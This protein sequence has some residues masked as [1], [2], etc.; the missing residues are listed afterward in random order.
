MKC[1]GNLS[2][3]CLDA[4]NAF[5]EIERDCI[6]AALLA[7]PSLHLMLP[8]FDMLYERGS[9][10]LWFCDEHGNYVESHFSRSGV[11]KGCVLG[12]FLL[13]LAMNHVYDRVGALMGPDGVIYAYSDEVN[14]LSDPARMRTTLA[15]TPAIYMKVGLR[16]GW[17]L[18]KTG[19]ILPANSD[20]TT[21]LPHLDTGGGC[22]PHVVPGFL[23]CLKVLRHASNDPTFIT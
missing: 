1:D 2:A 12:A 13:C 20:P 19:L 21:F 18:G 8:M 7:N 22:L 23:S 17:G 11:R 14:L 4:I 16:I 9:G 3:A 10:E 5:G 15:T 6:R